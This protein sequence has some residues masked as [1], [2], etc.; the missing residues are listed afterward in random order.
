MVRSEEMHSTEASPDR[1]HRPAPQPSP[2]A[3]DAVRP[4]SGRQPRPAFRLPAIRPRKPVVLGV[5]IGHADIRIAKTIRLADKRY[6]LV[7]YCRTALQGRPA[8]HDPLF[9]KQLKEALEGI[10]ADQGRCEIW[11]AIPSARVELRCL[12]VPKL[13]KRQLAN[14]V[15]WTFS[16]KTAFNQQEELLDFDILGDITEEGVRKTEVLAFKAPKAEV[17]ALKETFE[18][19]GYPLSGISIVPFAVQ[20]LFRTGLLRHGQQDA[21]TLF[22]GRDWSRIAIYN[23]N[24]LV[25]ARGIK[26][27]MRSMVE[28]IQAATTSTSSD[29]TSDDVPLALA[30]E[31]E[32]SAMPSAVPEGIAAPEAQQ[33]FFEFLLGKDVSAEEQHAPSPLGH[34][35]EAVFQMLRPALDRLVR[36][37][38]RTFAH[39]S[40][41]FQGGKVKRLL[42]SGR[43]TANDMLID[44]L[45]KQL[46]LPTE[47]LNPFAADPAFIGDAVVPEGRADR[48]SF[49]PAIGLAVS[50]NSFTPNFL[51]T[52][53]DK[54]AEDRSQR[55]SQ[56]L[57]MGC[58]ACLL[59]LL[60]LFA[61]QE[62]RIS[63]KREAIA[64][65]DRQLLTFSPAAE[66]E[67][68]L[69]LFAQSRQRRQ[70]MTQLVENYLPVAMLQE[71]SRLTPPNVRLIDVTADLEP[72]A[73]QQ[74]SSA[75]RITVDG[76]VFG[77]PGAFETALTSYLLTLRNSPI[78]SRPVVQNRRVE[79][80]DGREVLRF[81]A[82]LEIEG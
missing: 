65:L 77:A 50:H 53:K 12:R 26:T 23:Q 15:H 42:L 80:Y 25:L 75:G 36:Q 22:V 20:N 9:R 55:F 13:K 35:P 34:S 10:G 41:H 18:A 46:D 68:M 60:M 47:V 63:Q 51:H 69:A 76:L 32:A 33:C 45:A 81:Q 79:Y 6:Q 70:T 11:S 48:E 1:M 31:T 64:R 37:V 17:A 72:T 8:W 71:L 24:H 3:A 66:K 78:F 39:Y 4:P 59:A 14:A 19:V 38:E 28:A 49:L 27:G 54:A 7:D 5:E 58:M 73:G 61:W 52:H 43:I 21:C 40:L 56:R 82:V 62:Q 30:S 74:T 57:L 2:T 67:I 16:T 29:G 44:H